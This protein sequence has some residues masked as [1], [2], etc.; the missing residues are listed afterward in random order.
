VSGTK[1][2]EVFHSINKVKNR[3]LEDNNKENEG[4]T[5]G[6]VEEKNREND[7]NECMIEI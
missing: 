5:K 6:Y 2:G 3:R 7:C 4:P 1:R